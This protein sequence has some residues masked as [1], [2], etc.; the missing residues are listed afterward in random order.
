[1]EVNVATSLRYVVITGET[2]KK[3][4]FIPER[5]EPCLF[6]PLCETFGNVTQTS[7]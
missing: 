2:S 1:M 7:I 4:R 3:E 5:L 6:E